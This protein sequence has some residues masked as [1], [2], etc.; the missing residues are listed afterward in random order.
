MANRFRQVSVHFEEVTRE[1]GLWCTACAL[2]S[3]WRFVYAVSHDTRMHLQTR[4]HCDECE[5]SKHVVS[6]PT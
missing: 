3:G 1:S 6:D 2:P 4:T 5:S